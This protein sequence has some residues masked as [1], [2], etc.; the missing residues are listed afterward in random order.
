MNTRQK[1]LGP[2]L[3]ENR[4]HADLAMIDVLVY[5]ADE[6]TERWPGP[7][8]SDRSGGVV[9]TQTNLSLSRPR[10]HS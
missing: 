8:A 10:K 3:G 2:P 5:D 4:D 6:A 7:R 9:L 1:P